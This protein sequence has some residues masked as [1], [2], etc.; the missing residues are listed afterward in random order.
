MQVAKSEQKYAE[1]MLKKLA[2]WAVRY[3]TTTVNGCY[4]AL[5]TTL[6]GND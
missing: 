2:K 4:W 1:L 6:A 5:L 3:T